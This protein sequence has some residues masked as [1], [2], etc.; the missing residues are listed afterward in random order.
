MRGLAVAGSVV[1]LGVGAHGLAGGSL[2]HGV[3]LLMLGGVAAILAAVVTAIPSLATRPAGLVPVLAT[4]Q[5]L[6]HLALTLGDA[7]GSH[8][9]THASVPM[10]LTHTVAV[11]LCASL[12]AAAERIGPRALAALHRILPRLLAALPVRLEPSRPH[13]IADVRPVVVHLGVGSIAR[14]GPPAVV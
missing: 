12:I 4:G 9:G 8:T 10:L 2:P 7:H 11:L 14:R 13:V 5:V 6:S 1:A 3:T